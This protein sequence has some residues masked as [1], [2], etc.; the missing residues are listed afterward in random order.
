MTLPIK[1]GCL[2]EDKISTIY[3]VVDENDEPLYVVALTSS[4]PIIEAA[5]PKFLELLKTYRK[6]IIYYSLLDF[7]LY[8]HH[9]TALEHLKRKIRYS[10]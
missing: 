1:D 7:V 10:I 6:E 8:F 5:S 3:V 2:D 9:A 4:G